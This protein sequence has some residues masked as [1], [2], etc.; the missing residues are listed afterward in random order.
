MA[1]A[2][3]G[4]TV[5]FSVSAGDIIYIDAGGVGY[6]DVDGVRYSFNGE[7]YDISVNESGTASFT[8]ISGSCEYFVNNVEYGSDSMSRA[9]RKVANGLVASTE[10]GEALDSSGKPIAGFY[11]NYK[12]AFGVAGQSTEMGQTKYLD[13]LGNWVPAAFNSP[14]NNIY[15]PTPTA[16]A[17]AGSFFTYACELL[18][19]DRI[20]VD[21]K[22]CAV[23]GTSI[24]DWMGV[25]ATNGRQNSYAYRGKRSSLG[26]GDPG[27][28]GDFIYVNGATW[29]ATTGNKHL[30]FA[31]SDTPIVVNGINVYRD[32][33]Y[34]IKETNLLSAAS[35]P[36]FPGSPAVGNTVVDG[37]ITWTCIAVGVLTPDS[38]TSRIMRVTQDGVDPYFM[39]ARLRTE[40]MKCVVPA[41]KRFVQFQNGQADAGMATALY[42]MG[43]RE[44]GKF[45]AQDPYNIKVIFGL[46]IYYPAQ[47]QA[48]WDLLETALSGA[49]LS[50]SPNYSTSPLT[51]QL[52]GAGYT[53]GTLGT[54]T[55]NYTF[56]YGASL[57]RIFG[58]ATA[59]ILQPNDPHPTIDGAILCA[60]AIAPVLSR[61][62]RNSQT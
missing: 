46:S 32:P 40:L 53:L 1:T 35:P 10:S 5:N 30:C 17:G 14:S 22:N 15:E 45:F 11:A 60:K 41:N 57:Y 23:G 49:G 29:E 9:Q 62:F 42:A 58:T 3:L 37:A 44:F 31:N 24:V 52:Q 2:E 34:I 21:L 6:V 36:T 43:L 54:V 16:P 18:A 47:T 20:R 13:G 8:L 48:N 25:L 38:G 33:G 51:V 4:K 12:V 50:G 26:S 28:R 55:N 19:K 56:Y 27:T 59:P 61:I 7:Q 39:C